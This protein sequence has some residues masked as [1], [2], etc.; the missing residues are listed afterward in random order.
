MYQHP[1]FSKNIGKICTKIINGFF[2][3]FHSNGVYTIACFDKNPD[4]NI[5]NTLIKTF[6][7][8]LP[9]KKYVHFTT[10]Y[11]N[12]LSIKN[13]YYTTWYFKNNSSK[14]SKIS[15]IKNYF[16]TINQTFLRIYPEKLEK[17]LSI[18]IEYQEKFSF[19]IL[20]SKTFKKILP[21]EKY[22]P[23]K[24]LNLPFLS[25]K[26]LNYTFLCF[27][28]YSTKI[29][30]YSVINNYLKNIDT[31]Q[32]FLNYPEKSKKNIF[33]KNEYQKQDFNI[34]LDYF[35]SPNCLNKVSII[36][37]VLFLYVLEN[38]VEIKIYHSFL[39][40]VG[41]SFCF[42]A[43]HFSQIYDVMK[44]SVL[45]F[46]AK[47]CLNSF[48]EGPLLRDICFLGKVLLTLKSK[49]D[50]ESYFNFVLSKRTIKLQY[51]IVNHG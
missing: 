41:N 34:M 11:F 10:L 30:K 23:F 9:F 35:N 16:A 36:S 1:P 21:F 15:C 46:L 18:K 40:I 44:I 39:A 14:I 22:V 7:K 20:C 4:K 6:I 31:N 2:G 3:R 17:N 27:K 32:Y 42:S 37:L 26:N 50:I 49:I 43:E 28:N 48:M 12:Y 5:D 19:K 38:W 51:L 8:Y 45:K 47:S 13:S 29:P 24:K 25:I 33:G